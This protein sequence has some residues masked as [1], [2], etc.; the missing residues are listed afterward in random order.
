MGNRQPA[1][2][3]ETRYGWWLDVSVFGLLCGLFSLGIVMLLVAR[4]APANRARAIARAV[5]IGCA[6]ALAGTACWYFTSTIAGWVIVGP[7]TFWVMPLMVLFAWPAIR[8]SWR[9]ALSYRWLTLGLVLTMGPAIP[10]VQWLLPSTEAMVEAARPYD[11]GEGESRIIRPADSGAALR[12]A[13]IPHLGT[14]AAPYAVVS[15]FDYT[16][17]DSRANER[18]LLNLR[19]RFGSQVVHVPVLYPLDPECNPK[20]TSDMVASDA[21]SC[22]YA[23]LSLAVWLAAPESF[24]AFHESLVAAPRRQQMPTVEDAQATAAVL[25]GQENLDRA[26]KDPRV[27]QM[28]AAAIAAKP[29]GLSSGLPSE[30]VDGV[31]DVRPCVMWRGLGENDPIMVA[32]GQLGTE[33]LLRD[34]EQH[35]GAVPQ[36]STSVASEGEDAMTG[37]LD[38]LNNRN[39]SDGADQP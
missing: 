34:F 11:Y 25:V 6:A 31:I 15:F 4:F 38:L 36:S 7:V 37:L 9:A 21:G 30:A 5:T 10:L 32:I 13:D 17:S 14:L 35:T 19:E 12:L 27:E 18:A 22:A 26:L 1:P 23:R 20:V 3:Q 39:S 24:A 28:L 29:R 8:G 33:G 2:W 16:S